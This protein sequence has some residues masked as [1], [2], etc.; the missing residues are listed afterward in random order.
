MW[1]SS[2]IRRIATL[3]NLEIVQFISINIFIMKRS[4][5]TNEVVKD[6]IYANRHSHF[7]TVPLRT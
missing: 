7:T 3:C 4:S 2:I 1:N 6:H 5:I